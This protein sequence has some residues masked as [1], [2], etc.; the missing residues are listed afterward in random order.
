M[1]PRLPIVLGCA[2]PA[3][4]RLRLAL[5]AVAPGT[6]HLAP[7]AGTRPAFPQPLRHTARGFHVSVT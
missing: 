2:L 6:P 4:H 1:L 7:S 5:Q 3:L